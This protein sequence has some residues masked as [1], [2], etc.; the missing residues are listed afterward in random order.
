MSEYHKIQTVFKRDPDTKFKTLLDGD[1]SMSEFQYLKD[2]KWEFTEKVDGTNIRVI[3]GSDGSVE[4]RGRTDRAQIPEPLKH[5][6]EQLFLNDKLES[7]FPDGATLYGEGYGSKIQKVGS[8]YSQEQDFVLFDVD[9]GGWWLERAAVVDVSLSLGIQAVPVV[10]YGS[11]YE[12]V[13]IC[14]QGF[15]SHWGDF[16]AEGIVARPKVELKKRCGGRIITKL[17]L[18]DF[19]EA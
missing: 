8:N 15:T 10:G 9:V 17:K 19:K 13:E 2:N 1:Y 11:I 4:F 3:I 14:K 18:K 12:M 16:Q 6:L 7:Q 5:R